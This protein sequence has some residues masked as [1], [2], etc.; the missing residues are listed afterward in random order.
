MLKGMTSKI[1]DKNM[2]NNIALGTKL[3][4]TDFK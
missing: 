2:I 1:D 3:K 4:N